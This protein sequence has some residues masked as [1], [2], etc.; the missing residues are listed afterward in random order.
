M[1]FA[2]FCF[3][4]LLCSAGPG[5]ISGQA[6]AG[7]AATPPVEDL[8]DPSLH[9]RALA[10]A[11]PQFGERA[12]MPTYTRELWRVGWRTGDP[13]DLYILKPKGVEHPPVVLFLYGFPSD[14]D[15]FRNE[16]WAQAVTGHGF[17]VV[18]FVSALTGA[19]YHDQPWKT[20]FVSELPKT[21][22]ATVHDVSMVLNYLE[23]RKDLDATRAGIFG[24]GSGGAI[25]LVAAANDPRLRAVDAL[26]PWGD[27]PKWLVESPVISPGLPAEERAMYR[28]KAFLDQLTKLDPMTVL[29]TLPPSEVRLRQTAF[30]QETPP[31]V[32]AALAAKLPAGA[33][34]V[35]YATIEEYRAQGAADGRFLEWFRGKLR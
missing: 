22:S 15:R 17:A 26:D 34:R 13:I 10:S 24:Q 33:D 14:T 19:R 9:G 35:R 29:P 2:C 7:Q 8:Q 16:A 20:W 28:S 23:T 21:L 1:R 11:T 12:E 18:G 3:L 27:W 31:D 32:Q 5:Q 6:A 30:N 4:F 25:A